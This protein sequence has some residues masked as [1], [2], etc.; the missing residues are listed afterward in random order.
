[1][2]GSSNR[3]VLLAALLIGGCASSSTKELE[4]DGVQRSSLLP[5]PLGVVLG[6][7]A[8]APFS[9]SD[10]PSG[11][12]VGVRMEGA[13]PVDATPIRGG[14]VFRRGHVS[15]ADVVVRASA[16]GV[17][18]FVAFRERPAEERLRY[19]IALGDAVA[20]MRL[21]ANS[22]ELLDARGTPRLRVA[23]PYL[24]DAE[25]ERGP[26]V[27]EVED[28]EYDQDPR[29][30]HR[31][32]V[33]PPGASTCTL[34]VTWTGAPYPLVVDPFWTATGMMMAARQ[35]H[36]STLL[37][38]GRVLVAGGLDGVP[39]SS[40]E[41]FDPMTE[42]WSVTG[43][44]TGARHSHDGALL[45][46]G[47]VLVAGGYDGPGT[48]ATVETYDPVTGQWSATGSLQ[49]QRANHSVVQLGDG[50]VLA[51]GGVHTAELDVVEL[52]DPATAQW[53]MAANL[54][55]P[56]M[57]HEASMLLDGRVLVVG[58]ELAGAELT[59][60]EIYDPVA[61][62]W[63]TVAM[64]GEPRVEHTATTLVDGRVLVVGGWDGAAT[65]KSAE[66]FD[67]ATQG[68]TAVAPST[69]PWRL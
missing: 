53:S 40:A 28:C 13:L 23:P 29:A 67:P 66:V 8:D 3:Y 38:D 42:T 24:I 36:S 12:S 51:A 46:D 65:L 54:A 33:V 6:S 1:M 26:V 16:F 4:T 41:V 7:T 62:A 61:G 58:G 27:L 47:R 10:R 44:L 9:V 18:D 68:W 57:Q 37:S 15:G 64:M 49:Q 11:L 19:Q 25:G 56:R 32:P 14:V 20:G 34:T 60:T 50:R 63:A 59:S 17:E 22:L 35:S 31:R 45:N 69:N 2:G 43:A 30:P 21:F 5:G 39:L 55:V 52:W 48:V